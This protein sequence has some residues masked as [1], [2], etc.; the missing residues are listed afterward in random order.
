MY[1][2]GNHFQV[3][4]AKSHLSIQD[5]GVATTF[6][7]ECHSHLGDQNPMMALLEYVG[8]IE[9]ILELDYDMFQTI[10][11]LC[12]WVVANYGGSNA[13]V[14]HDEYTRRKTCIFDYSL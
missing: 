2:F 7:Q 12:N 9:K 5:L 6:E 4:S 13:I 11:F 10:V 14:N 3:A 1:T 8:W